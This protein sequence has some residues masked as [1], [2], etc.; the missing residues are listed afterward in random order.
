MATRIGMKR[1]GYSFEV[2]RSRSHPQVQQV[3]DLQTRAERDRTG[4]FFVE[5]IR[6]VARAIEHS[7]PIE[8]VV[9]APDLLTNSF[10]QGLVAELGR[11]GVSRLEVTPE[12]FQFLS[13]SE[14]PQGVGVVA[15]QQ[16]EPLERLPPGQGLCWVALAGVRSAGNLG[17]IFRTCD[18]VG[19]AGVILLDGAIDPYDPAATRASMGSLFTVQLARASLSDLV[20]WKRWHG[21]RLI[22][23]SPTGSLDYHAA[24]YP[25]PVVLFMGPERHGLSRAQQEACDHLVRIPMVGA[26]DS[27]NLAVATAVLLYEVFNQ[28][29][30]DPATQDARPPPERPVYRRL[31]SSTISGT[32][33][34]GGRVATKRQ[35]SAT[36]SGWRAWA[37]TSGGVGVGRLRTRGVSVRPGKRTL[38]RIPRAFSSCIVPWARPV[39]PCLLAW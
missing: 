19:A 31:G 1:G 22:G 17:T 6:A 35:A 4:L 37:I 7:A 26:A 18:A 36:S 3:R 11:K 15:R 38:V 34:R 20:R 12:I 33:A 24:R 5:G 14:E 23:T 29:R 10:G 21:C 32:C 39:R 27:L 28:R 13:L 25:A 16:W 8:R 30:A 9:V 2:V